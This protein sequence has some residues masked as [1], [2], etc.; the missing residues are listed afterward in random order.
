MKTV[1][2]SFVLVAAESELEGFGVAFAVKRRVG[3]AVDRNRIRRRLR[4]LLAESLPPP[5]RGMDFLLIARRSALSKPWQRLK[6]EMRAA[7]GKLG[8]DE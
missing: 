1:T 4:H 2:P 3:S 7:L 5:K 6:E 8:I